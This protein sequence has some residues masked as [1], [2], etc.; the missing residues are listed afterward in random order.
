[1]SQNSQTADANIN[2][3]IR[4]KR[5]LLIDE[6]GSRMGE[7]LTKDALIIAQEKGMDLVE[8][9]SVGEVVVCKVADY[10]KMKYE[11]KKKEAVS[12]KNQVHQQLKEIKLRPLTSEHDMKI[13]A[14]NI[15]KF[16]S[17]GN[18]V[19]VSVQ[20][21]GRELSHRNIGYEQCAKIYSMVEDI[22]E[23]ETPPH[24]EGRTIQMTLSPS[25][26]KKA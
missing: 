4:A 2:E 12:R 16:L 15:Q 1:M 23:I 13:K 21:Q 11:M 5:V 18:K 14:Q 22:S 6:N 20:F 7:F 17:Q 8:V 9:S 10:G 24:S 26:G 3:N 19:K 25:S